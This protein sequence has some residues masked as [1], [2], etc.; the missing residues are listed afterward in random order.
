MPKDTDP[1]LATPTFQAVVEWDKVSPEPPLFQAKHPQQLLTLLMGHT[2][3][4][5]IVSTYLFVSPIHN[6]ITA[7]ILKYP[8]NDYFNF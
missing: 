8:I 4:Q 1:H 2:L 6:S 7:I 5:L 3:P